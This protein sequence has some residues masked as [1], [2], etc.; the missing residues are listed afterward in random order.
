VNQGYATKFNLNLFIKSQV[1]IAGILQE[2]D[3]KLNQNT[4]LMERLKS[5]AMRELPKRILYT[6][7]FPAWKSHNYRSLLSNQD[8]LDVRKASRKSKT[9]N[10]PKAAPMPPRSLESNYPIRMNVLTERKL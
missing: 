3:P 1:T 7:W 8:L 10:T 2:L 6:L 4:Y 9:S 5:L